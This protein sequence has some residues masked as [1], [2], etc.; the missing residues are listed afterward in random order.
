MMGVCCF[1]CF[2]VCFVCFATNF[3]IINKKSTQNTKKVKLYKKINTN[4]I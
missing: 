2:V 1:I 3:A 4:I